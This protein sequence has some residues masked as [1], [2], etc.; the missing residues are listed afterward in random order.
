MPEYGRHCNKGQHPNAAP[1]YLSSN[2][3][4]HGVTTGFRIYN[5][6]R[7]KRHL[8]QWLDVSNSELYGHYHRCCDPGTLPAAERAAG[9]LPERISVVN[10]QPSRSLLVGDNRVVPAFVFLL[11]LGLF[12]NYL[13]VIHD[14]ADYKIEQQERRQ[15]K[16]D[17]M[18]SSY[19]KR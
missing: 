8:F 5:G 2:G 4:G 11:L 10:G 12:H 9:H 18:E 19:G 15:Y 17:H 13:V 16:P 6:L 14:C 3:V 1:Y 7:R